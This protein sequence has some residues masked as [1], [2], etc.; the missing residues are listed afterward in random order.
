MR[1]GIAGYGNLGRALEQIC[2]GAEDIVLEGIF[3]RRNKDEVKTN[4]TPI[5]GIDELSEHKD[6][7]DVL[8]LCYGSSLDLPRLTPSIAGDFNTVDSFDN[9]LR[10]DEYKLSVNETAR[11][12]GKTA[13]ISLGWDP[14]LLS[15]LRL[16]LSSFLP[17]ASVNT[18]WGR[19]VSQGHSEALRRI[20]GVNKAVQYTVPREDALTLAS[21]VCHPL[22]DTERHRRVCYIAAEKGKED[23]ITN[24]VLSMEN[25]F[26]GYETELH[27]VSNEEIEK[28]HSSSHR[29]RIYAL[30]MSG[31][32]KEV[33]H[34]AYFD[35]DLGSNA[36]MTASI[37]LAS[38]RACYR[39]FLD[40]RVG[41][42]TAF[43]IPPSYFAPKMCVNVNNYL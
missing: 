4:G 39:M 6:S 18:F 26:S 22:T 42:Y 34:S 7:I 23:L 41:A 15:L 1:I 33:K 10:I 9:H 25:Y 21:L 30:G 17:N 24:E 31:K 2:L 14:G 28:H 8:A 5:Y 37:L 11:L 12:H 27:F 35:L 32:Y 16:Y 43:D 19:G 13:L 36:D 20:D 29:G 38:A 40:G 3:T